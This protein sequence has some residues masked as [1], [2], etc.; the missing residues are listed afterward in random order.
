MWVDDL[1]PNHLLKC[2]TCDTCLQAK[3]DESPHRRRKPA[4][5]CERNSGEESEPED[6]LGRISVDL[7]VAS[8]SV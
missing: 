4:R 3:L 8:D 1:N 2:R 5:N 7:I 6:H